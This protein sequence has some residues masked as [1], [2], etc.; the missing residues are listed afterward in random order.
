MILLTECSF[1][2]ACVSPIRLVLLW[3]WLGVLWWGLLLWGWV[4]GSAGLVWLVWGVCPRVCSL[5][6]G[7]QGG[8]GRGSFLCARAPVERVFAVMKRVFNGQSCA[9]HHPVTGLR[10]DGLARICFNLLQMTTLS[11]RALLVWVINLVGEMGENGVWR[12]FVEAHEGVGGLKR[13]WVLLLKPFFSLFH[14]SKYSRILLNL[15]PFFRV[16]RSFPLSLI[17]LAAG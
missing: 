15:N 2:E 11:R 13:G 4:L 17:F 8:R 5:G 6:I 16:P 14:A 9:G 1:V 12:G 3:F 10:E 7:L